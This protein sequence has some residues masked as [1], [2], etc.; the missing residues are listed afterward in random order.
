MFPPVSRQDKRP[1]HAEQKGKG[2]SSNNRRIRGNP[3]DA[4]PS[5]NDQVESPIVMHPGAIQV[6]GNAKHNLRPNYVWA[7]YDAVDDDARR[8]QAAPVSNCL[9]DLDDQPSHDNDPTAYRDEFRPVTLGTEGKR[10]VGEG[11]V[12]DTSP[13]K[14]SE[15]RGKFQNTPKPIA[16]PPVIDEVNGLWTSLPFR[17][18]TPQS[19]NAFV[20]NGGTEI[21]A[22]SRTLRSGGRI[23]P[24]ETLGTITKH[25]ATTPTHHNG[26]AARGWQQFSQA[27]LDGSPSDSANSTPR[28]GHRSHP[29]PYRGAINSRSR[30]GYPQSTSH[31]QPEALE[32]EVDNNDA[33]SSYTQVAEWETSTTD[34]DELASTSLREWHLVEPADDGDTKDLIQF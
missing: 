33:L 9:V 5:T 7:N 12:V 24:A 10:K 8:R 18:R 26:A 3:K 20:H 22:G 19:N 28:A 30:G 13:D 16:A 17:Q 23:Q 2:R 21:S 15:A 6:S 32:L 1:S 34:G 11:I 29:G 31:A 27:Q 14:M 4:I 25:L